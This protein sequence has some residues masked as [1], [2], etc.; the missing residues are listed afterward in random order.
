MRW[1]RFPGG[2]KARRAR[3]L[4]AARAWQQ[5]ERE[6]ARERIAKLAQEHHGWNGP[7][8]AY[9]VAPLLTRGQAVRTRHGGHR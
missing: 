8:N 2:R 3:V 5:A 6:A 9:R 4:D 7:T 1:I